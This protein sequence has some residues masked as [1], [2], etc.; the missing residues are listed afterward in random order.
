VFVAATACVVF[1]L[2]TSLAV[3][4]ARAQVNE[5]DAPWQAHPYEGQDVP[6]PQVRVNRDMTCGCGDGS[7]EDECNPATEWL[8]IFERN[9]QF[10]FRGE[11]LAWW[12]KSAD[13]PP[14]VST[15]V[16]GEPGTEI[17][18]GGSDGNSSVHSGVRLGLTYWLTPCHE[19][20]FDVNY[21]FLANNATTFDRD[22][23]QTPNLARPFF[24]V[25]TR[26]MAQDAWILAN[27]TAGQ[28][29]EIHV[30]NS[31]E[32]QCLEAVVRRSVIQ[33]CD[34]NLDFVFGYRY[35]RLVEDLTINDSTIRLGSTVQKTDVFDAR[36]EF[37]GL[38]LGFISTTRHCRWSLELLAKLAMGNTR[39]RMDVSGRTRV[40]D[41][42]GGSVNL[43]GG[44]LAL[45]TNSIPV[46]RNSFSTMPELGVTLGYDLTCNLKAR[47]GYSVVYW[48]SVMRP[49][50]QID[51]NINGTQVPPTSTGLQGMASPESRAVGSDFWAQG[52]NVGLDYRY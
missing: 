11:Y 49:G 4:T 43:N 18:Y 39:S 12:T 25:A 47:V 5:P 17:L 1:V 29:G 13:L 37:N 32:M 28:T 31:L 42:Q 22:S 52:L 34:R 45:P 50:D 24:N 2:G 26:V 23:T 15:G 19:M 33:Q 46:E 7:C 44:L 36:N 9:G 51:T 40:T 10:S 30:N 3:S 21:T 41:S 14:L 16:I 20:A 27:S 48:S 35:G 38:E 6:P 8:H